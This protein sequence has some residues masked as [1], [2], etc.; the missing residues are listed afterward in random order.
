MEG[1][2]K[3]DP[4]QLISVAGELSSGGTNVQQLT[5]EMVRIMTA[6]GTSMSGEAISS[7]IAKAQGLE[8]DITKINGMIQEHSKDLQEMAQIYMNAESGAQSEADALQTSVIG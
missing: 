8:G 3:V 5:S 2:I 7:L 6:I 4:Q 1:T